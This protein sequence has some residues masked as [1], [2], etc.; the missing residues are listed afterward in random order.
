VDGSLVAR[1]H[2]GSVL[3]DPEAIAIR[4]IRMVTQGTVETVLG[5]VVAI[6]ADS[7]CVHGDNP[8]AC[9]ILEKVRRS[10]DEAGL[11]ISPLREVLSL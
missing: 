3:H 6:H 11:H 10:L 7:I 1:S 4:V 9:R 8:A 5:E 2:K